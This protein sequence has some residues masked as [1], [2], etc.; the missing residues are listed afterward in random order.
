M[1]RS[2]WLCCR[3]RLCHRRL[4]RCRRRRNEHDWNG[5]ENRHRYRRHRY[6]CDEK[7]KEFLITS[8]LW[9][10]FVYNVYSVVGCQVHVLVY[11]MENWK[12]NDVSLSPFSL[13]GICNMFFVRASECVFCRASSLAPVS[14]CVSCIAWSVISSLCAIFICR[15]SPSFFFHFCF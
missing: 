3:L 5:H 10:V 13:Y 7:R 12:K 4:R 11:Q 2:F 9:L 1:S 15:I 14:L 8:L 6:G